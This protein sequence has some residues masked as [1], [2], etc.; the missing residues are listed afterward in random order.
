MQELIGKTV[1]FKSLIEDQ[2]AYPETG[3]R[4]KIVNI[5]A[6]DT[7]SEDPRDHL[8]KI[9]F[10]YS[11]FDEYNARFESSNYYDKQGKA[12]LTAREAGWYEPIEEIYFASPETH[13]FEN[14]FTVLDD[15]QRGLIEEF[16]ASGE[17][18]YVAWLEKKVLA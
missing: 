5:N 2:E 9:M 10:D 7:R 1:E 14:Y 4:A 11:S 18:N 15:N 8:Y 17:K 16:K 12:C 6:T 13:P 3:M